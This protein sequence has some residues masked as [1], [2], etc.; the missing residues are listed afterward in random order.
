VRLNL[1]LRNKSVTLLELL[2]AVALMS[3]VVL[4]FTSIDMFSRQNVVSSDRRARIQNAV[5]FCM[6]H[7]SKNI[8]KAVGSKNNPPTTVPDTIGSDSAIKIW[9]DSNDNGK[10][11]AST[12]DKQIAYAYNATTYQL[13]YYANF[14]DAP[15]SSEILSDKIVSDLGVSNVTY[16][17]TNNYIGIK[18]KGRWIPSDAN[19]TPDNPEVSMYTFI[20]MPA[21]SVN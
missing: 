21:V 13:K 6:A 1:N 9:V 11:D 19:V 3:L 18:I 15:A 4:G 17:S 5:A 8:A 10:L 16:S 7:M 12:I 2:L 14:T 20:S